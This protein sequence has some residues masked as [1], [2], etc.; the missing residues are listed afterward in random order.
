ME[1]GSIIIKDVEEKKKI[2]KDFKPGLF[3]QTKSFLDR[4]DSLFCTLSEQVENIR[5]YSK[6]AGYL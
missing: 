4:D 5:I 6:I 1:L 2:D 3:L